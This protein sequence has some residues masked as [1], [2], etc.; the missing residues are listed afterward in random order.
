MPDSPPVPD[1][2]P[3]PR[4]ARQQVQLPRDLHTRFA[5]LCE[6]NGVTAATL[7]Y[8]WYTT[9][10]HAA[11][12]GQGHLLPRGGRP[13]RGSVGEV[14]GVPWRQGRAEYERCRRWLAAAGTDP[15]T[16]LRAAVQTFVAV[17]GDIL[18]TAWPPR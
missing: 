9:A 16:V 6:R 15:T 3:P 17:D 4:G 1:S 13:R 12:H 14:V 8:G 7:L 18:A 10:A 11:A 5:A 2:A